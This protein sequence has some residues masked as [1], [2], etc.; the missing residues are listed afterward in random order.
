[1]L[2]TVK[3]TIVQLIA[4]F[5]PHFA[6]ELWERIGK[7]F[8]IFNS[9]WPEYDEELIKVDEIEILIQVLGKPKVKIMMPAQISQ[10]EMEKLALE[11]PKVKEAI[12]GKTVR[13]VIC[14]PG[15]LVNIVAN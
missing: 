9:D 10:E 8:S 15:R 12:E 6:E 13:K 2:D 3:V 11:N 14:V 5:A 4:P 1:M 7:P